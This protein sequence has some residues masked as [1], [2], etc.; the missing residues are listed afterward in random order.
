[1]YWNIKGGG[2][3]SNQCDAMK[4]LGDIGLARVAV[5][6]TICVHLNCRQ[7]F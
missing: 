2:K 6:G 1:M 3:K 7:G 4:A 5:K